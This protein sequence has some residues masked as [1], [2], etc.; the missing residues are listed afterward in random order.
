MAKLVVLTEGFA[1]RTCD[2]KTDRT[3]VGRI[4][5]NMFQIPEQSI[6]S[7]HCEILL[8][9]KDIAV[10][11][12]DS[13]NG[14]YIDGDAIKEAVLKPGQILRLGKVE[15]KLD[16][17]TPV[18][19]TPPAAPAKKRIDHTTAMPQGV[20]LNEF[21]PGT[22]TI[23]V[24]SDFKKRSGGINK[25][26]LIGFVVLGVIVVAVMVMMFLKTPGTPTP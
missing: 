21:E 16:D 9:G 8:R 3:T 19:A 17:G 11:D 15:L 4:E 1:G 22:H 18:A 26:F 2:L 23:K 7:H 12:L 10:K 14:T 24:A 5:D 13:T 20:K 25:Y 6:S